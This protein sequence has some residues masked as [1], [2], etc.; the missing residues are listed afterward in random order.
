MKKLVAII[1]VFLLIISG[2]LFNLSYAM[3][4]TYTLECE[5]SKATEEFDL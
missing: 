1:G 4:T 3:G 5:V 2:I